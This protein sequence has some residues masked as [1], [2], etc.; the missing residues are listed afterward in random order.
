MSER[1]KKRISENQKKQARQAGRIV[2]GIF[3]VL[4]A[5]MV[6]CIVLA[7]FLSD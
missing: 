2:N 5:L 4:I 6:V 3:V 7:A 1:R